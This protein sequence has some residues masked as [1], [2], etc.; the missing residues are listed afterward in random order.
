MS[1]QSGPAAP[2]RRA[3]SGYDR[4]SLPVVPG[5]RRSHA[6]DRRRHRGPRP[7]RL[8]LGRR[9]YGQPSGGRPPGPL[10]PPRPMT[11]H[12]SMN[13]EPP[14]ALAELDEVI[15]A[16]F[17]EY[18]A[19]VNQALQANRDRCTVF[20]R[21]HRRWFRLTGVAMIVFSVSLPA[22][23]AAS[24]SGRDTAISVLAVAVA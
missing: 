4:P 13:H 23:T 24:F 1:D 20:A 16:R 9:L 18:A 22:L 6:A 2:L 8:P 5:M 7:R 15:S 3:G 21:R 17:P 12:A 10:P 11:A 14:P 19:L